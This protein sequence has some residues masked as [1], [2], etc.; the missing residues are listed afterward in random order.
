VN[1]N[2]TRRK[3]RRVQRDGSVKHQVRWVVNYREPVTGIRRQ[4]F[5]DRLKQA[6]DKRAELIAAT[7]RGAYV[8]ARNSLAVADVVGSW[9]EAKRAVLK[10]NTIPGYEARCHLI[11]GPL[12]PTHARRAVIRS[13]TGAAP[14]CELIPLLGG[15]KVSELTTRQIRRWHALIAGDVGIYS[16][17]KAAMLFK[18]ALAVA[19][20]D[21]GF[22]PPVF[23]TGLQRRSDRPAKRLLVSSQI[24]VVIE[25]AF[26]SDKAVYC[27]FPFLT[28]LR[29]SEM[30]GLLWND[31]AL[32]HG[33]IRIRRVQV[34]RS[35]ELIEATKTAAGTR[36]IPM[37]PVL[38]DL[39]IS[40]HPRCPLLYGAPHRV[41]PGPEGGPLF[42]NNYRTRFWLPTLASLGL[43]AVSPHS[44]RHAFIST[45]QAHGV[46]VAT[47][48]KLAGHKSPAVTLGFYTHSVSDANAAVS[49]LD[50]AFV[51]DRVTE[52]MTDT[53]SDCIDAPNEG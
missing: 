33:V 10:P 46:D 8:P 21:G 7:D 31:V 38:R 4:L 11:V 24:A 48:A 14:R 27:A 47:A 26:H 13:G 30:L 40:W 49:V 32:E 9:L 29:S 37:S 42:Y 53:R 23:P 25:A 52:Y 44:A 41:F 35:G 16:A 45:L 22:R 15:V 5:F 12:L 50:R 28:G 34:K 6:Q 19:A 51:T 18:A 20:E 1:I 3:R 36:D 39:L 43:P 17:N 2:I